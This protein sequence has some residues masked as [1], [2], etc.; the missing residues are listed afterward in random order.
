MGWLS[1]HAGG[2]GTLVGGVLG[3]MMGGPVGAA[4]GMGLVGAAGGLMQGDSYEDPSTRAYDPFK[5]YRG[6]FGQQLADL[7]AGSKQFSPS[8]PSYQFRYDQGLEAVNRSL[9]AQG[10]LGSGLQMKSL[11]DYGQASASQ[12]YGNEWNRL[13]SLAGVNQTAGVGSTNQ[14]NQF[15]QNLG[16]GLGL[17]QGF[18]LS[19]L[20]NQ[21]SSAGTSLVGG[22]IG[23]SLGSDF[24]GTFDMGMGNWSA[25]PGMM[26]GFV[27]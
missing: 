13:A 3:F 8:D 19:S 14:G 20:F 7:Q 16:A 24:G 1:E 25:N 22:D 4:V 11:M 17:A 18:G 2:I 21:G 15:M 9:A 5:G 26:S 27:W 12:E 23:G 10:Q 6:Y